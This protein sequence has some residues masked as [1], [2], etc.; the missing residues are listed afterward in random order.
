MR[1]IFSSLFLFLAISAT[2]QT[3]AISGFIED[4]LSRERL[5]GASIQIG[6]AAVLT[7]NYG[8]FTLRLSQTSSKII[9]I[10]H[11]GYQP[12]VQPIAFAKDT[13]LIIRLA[14]Q[15]RQLEAVTVQ[16]DFLNRTVE[17]GKYRLPLQLLRQA[18][19]LMGEADILK[20][21]QTLPGVQGGT[22][23]TAGIH[24]RGGS[25]D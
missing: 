25:P 19:A 5:P 17:P 24:V 2:G 12:K 15:A 16:G 10:Q 13:I 14:T 9:R 6:K 20:F 4:S 3:V 23:G 8:F 1:Y 21:I 22:E 11:I 7:N 18:P